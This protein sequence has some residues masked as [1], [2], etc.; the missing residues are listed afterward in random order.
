MS[1]RMDRINAM[2]LSN[3]EKLPV[4]Y[5][6]MKVN[7]MPRG[8]S[9]D[10]EFWNSARQTLSNRDAFET[11]DVTFNESD[12]PKPRRVLKSAPPQP[13]GDTPA[14]AE[15]QL[16]NMEFG[17]DAG[18]TVAQLQDF[19]AQN[20]FKSGVGKEFAKDAKERITAK[21]SDAIRDQ[22]ARDNGFEPQGEHEP[23]PV[24]RA[25]L[26]AAKKDPNGVFNPKSPNYR[27]FLDWH[28]QPFTLHEQAVDYWTS[29]NSTSQHISAHDLVSQHGLEQAMKIAADQ[30]SVV[31]K[32]L[33]GN[34]YG[35]TPKTFTT[36]PVG[37]AAG[38]ISKTYYDLRSTP[39]AI[40][41]VELNGLIEKAAEELRNIDYGYENNEVRKAKEREIRELKLEQADLATRL[42]AM[43]AVKYFS[44]RNPN[45]ALFSSG[46][47]AQEIFSQLG[48]EAADSFKQGTKV[49]R[50]LLL[51]EEYH[52]SFIKRKGDE[53]LASRIEKAL[54]EDGYFDLPTRALTSWTQT[55]KLASTF[56][57]H[58][59]GQKD[60]NS[61]G[62]GIVITHEPAASEVV[63]HPGMP[64][65][66]SIFAYRK[67]NGY[68]F[69]SGGMDQ[70]EVILRSE[71][72]VFRLTPENT[73]FVKF[74][75]SEGGSRFSESLAEPSER[76]LSETERNEL[77]DYIMTNMVRRPALLSTLAQRELSEPATLFRLGF[78]LHPKMREGL[79]VDISN[80]GENFASFSK[81][82]LVNDPDA[83]EAIWS[84]L[85]NESV[86][87][88]PVT[89]IISNASRGFE[90]PYH[91]LD[92]DPS[93]AS[94]DHLRNQE[95]V[96][97]TGKY[98]VNGISVENGRT[99][100]NLAE[101]HDSIT[102]NAH[103][104]FMPDS[105]MDADMNLDHEAFLDHLEDNYRDGVIPVS[106]SLPRKFW[107][108]AQRKGY[109]GDAG[110]F[111]GVF[112]TLGD[113]SDFYSGK[114]RVHVT[115]HLPADKYLEHLTPDMRYD[116]VQHF[117][118]EHPYA[119]GGD[120]YVN[121]PIPLEHIVS[122]DGTKFMPSGS[123][124]AKEGLS[125]EQAEFTGLEPAALGGAR[126][127]NPM[128]PSDAPS[129]APLSLA[130]APG[131]VYRQKWE[132]ARVVDGS[133]ARP[134]DQKLF[135][136]TV[137]KPNGERLEDTFPI[138]ALTRDKA[139]EGLKDLRR[140]IFTRYQGKADLM[141][142]EISPEM[143][144][145]PV[146]W[147]ALRDAAR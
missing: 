52:G 29:S 74:M 47:H 38:T 93:F 94:V 19:A 103:V 96:L 91:E 65:Y 78:E 132:Q 128:E 60:Y 67:A 18:Y 98:R 4:N 10:N 79:V 114:D 25:R 72:G 77:A 66:Q 40:R 137:V 41:H 104:W 119:D 95:E 13:V 126:V 107:E 106:H 5:E 146:D 108:A 123:E 118:E 131:E 86:D 102:P 70:K 62:T 15:W 39:E 116:D 3:A 35:L 55:E 7:F 145:G 111:D 90:V 130:A 100:V 112:A 71:P 23:N 129:A 68:K 109:L 21:E 120:V 22:L 84:P 87:D 73:K 11:R 42:S 33:Y 44:E 83:Q 115:A 27:M 144:S 85:G 63:M 45:T 136:V 48:S 97:V 9:A 61:S 20:K 88:L 49:Y 34:S 134:Q 54:A 135:L 64:T 122:V 57:R 127:P 113:K 1:T 124:S 16:S 69:N 142:S 99:F 36:E 50:G 26:E 141:V 53:T 140:K 8:N 117:V 76:Q 30:S 6:K 28:G 24:F 56:S 92:E 14:F 51:D 31:G 138:R 105:G 121:A 75:P 12:G 43:A 58:G 37:H 2:E 81:R 139:F 101:A 59:Q 147:A 125:L 89:Y 80:K 17:A 110:D 32:N 143:D 133:E 82:D 46:D